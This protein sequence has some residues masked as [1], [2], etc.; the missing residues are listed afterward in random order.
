MCAATLLWLAACDDAGGQ[1]ADA[2]PDA[3]ADTVLSDSAAD[4][5]SADAATDDGPDLPP[6]AAPQAAVTGDGPFHV[7]YRALEVT[8]TPQTFDTPR[9]LKV[10]VWY[11][12]DATSG[13]PAQYD[14]FIERDAIFAD[15]APAGDA[16]YPVLFFSHGNGGMPQQNWSMAERAATHGWLVVAPGHTGNTIFDY[17]KTIAPAMFLLR[18]MD[19][20][21]TLDAMLALPAA[22][23][24]AGR[25]SEQIGLAGHSFGGFTTLA[26][27]GATLSTVPVDTLCETD[28]SGACDLWTEPRR[29]L[30]RSGFHDPRF[31]ALIAMA[32]STTGE[33]LGAG[34]TATVTAPTLIMTG[35]LDQLTP[36]A[37]D[38]DPL[39][40]ALVGPQHLRVG[41]PTAGHYTF[42][43]GCEL[44][45]GFGDGCGEG[46]IEPE[47]ALPMI[48]AFTLAWLRQT[49][50]G[51]AAVVADL[52]EG[53]AET[54]P[55]EISHSPAAR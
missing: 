31:K 24:L 7:G 1:R 45:I 35:G 47:R 23:P 27:G 40:Q 39:W 5:A 13:K 46:F 49:L 3:A 16:P 8:Y 6:D 19:V 12:T 37:T 2:A 29:Q 54:D 21:A 55:L 51:D 17:D 42:S 11:P 18:P 52:I 22:D 33:I 15:A 9:T 41:F 44:G 36:D 50:Q 48:T 10:S 14:L 25:L 4:T 53:Y 26:I 32:P 28:T 34:A 20:R 38:G 30:T 43:N